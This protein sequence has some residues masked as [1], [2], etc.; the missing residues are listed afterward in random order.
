MSSSTSLLREIGSIDTLRQAWRKVREKGGG[1]G[2]DRVSCDE[3]GAELERNL[4]RIAAELRSGGYRAQ[5][6]M[7]VRP[8]FLGADDRALVI[9]TVRDRVM[10]RAVAD[11]LYPR[12]DRTLSDACRAFRRGR[13][14]SETADQVS[15]W[16]EEGAAWVLRADVRKFFDGIRPELLLEKLE[17]FVDDDDLKF[18]GRIVRSRVFDRDHVADM[19]VGI[20]QGSPLSPILANLYLNELDHRLLEG[21]PRYLRYCDDMIVCETGESGA[22][23]ALEVLIEALEPLGLGI[24]DRKTK[25][26]RAEDGFVFLG[27]Q[28]GALGRGPAVKAVEALEFR[29]RDL[30]AATLFDIGALDALYRGWSNYF[31]RHDDCWLESPIGVLGLLR[32]AEELDLEKVMVRRWTLE[33]AASPELAFRLAEAWQQRGAESQAWLELAAAHGGA[34]AGMKTVERWSSLLEVPVDGLR[35]LLRGLVGDAEARF[36]TLTEGVAQLGRYAVAQR[37]NAAGYDAFRGGEDEGE[38]NPEA[39]LVEEADYELLLE[40]FQG[41]EGVHAQESVSGSHRSFVPVNR[42]LIIDDW[43]AHLEGAKTLGLPLIRSDQSVLVAVLDVDICR[44]DL[45][46]RLG[47]PDELMGRALGAALRLRRALQLRGCATLLELSGHKGYHLWLR[48]AEP[49]PCREVRA[50]L[51]D[52]VAGV[53]S[54]PEVIR[55]EVFPTRDKVK[56]GVGPLIKLPLGLH[57]KTGG[58]CFLL[59]ERGEPLGDPYEALRSL[60][61]LSRAQLRQGLVPSPAESSSDRDEGARAS[62]GPR[63]TKLIERCH[64]LRFLVDKAE[65]ASYLT[66]GERSL[67][68][69]TLGHL[70]EEGVGAIHA[71]I[72][73]C[74]NYRRDVTERHLRKTPP[75]PISCPRVRELHPQITT[76]VGCDCRFRIRGAGYPTPLLHVL[77]TREIPAFQRQMEERGM[78]ERQAGDEAAERIEKERRKK[79]EELVMKIADRKRQ[80]RGL[81]AAIERLR[82]ELEAIFEELGEDRLELTMGVLHRVERGDGEGWKLEIEV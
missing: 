33:T 1:P 62:F 23:T 8:S 43:R 17:P 9:P 82:R 51:H 5:P 47:V 41:R 21:S 81:E 11:F 14:I 19:V 26:C 55:V 4:A 46:L 74:Y 58:R 2:I 75:S 28:Y 66:H 10:Q 68:R 56:Q 37:L 27:F 73:R 67:L 29:L 48:L 3:F 22:R 13:P 34:D 50:W 69:C 25:L 57:S 7:R 39:R 54:L 79:A 12:I 71:I 59:D 70:G 32:G 36:A 76:S 30:A 49:L 80:L 53:D 31:G 52:V 77:G 40:W 44:K 24:N 15:R 60:P 38:P 61:R 42:P 18:L 64:V 6:V 35:Q 78:K 45:D 16:I 20:P 63:V 65:R 72:S